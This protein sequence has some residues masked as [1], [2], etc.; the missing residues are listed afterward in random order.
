MSVNKIYLSKGESCTKVI[1]SDASKE[2]YRYDI[3]LEEGSAL[4]LTFLSIYGQKPRFEINVFLNGERAD[5]TLNGFYAVKE[6]QTADFVVNM[7]HNAP[8][9]TSRQLFKGILSG[10]GKSS[11]NG[12]I[13]VVPGAQQTEA[14][15]ANHNLLLSSEAKA[16]SKPQLEIYADDVKCS[17]GAT[18]GQLNE[19]ELFYLRSRGITY[20]EA[21]RLQIEAFAAEVIPEDIRNEVLPHLL[22]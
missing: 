6:Q 8:K 20:E 15:Q 22:P 2:E 12:L 3:V 11:F 7:V 9:C 14:Y 16:T 5:C 4:H 10:S 13:K 21:R 19:D 18:V 17:H 1:F